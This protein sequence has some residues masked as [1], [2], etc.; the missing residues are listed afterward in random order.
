M[1]EKY[2]AVK[3][4]VPKMNRVAVFNDDFRDALKGHWSNPASLG[5]A[6]GQT[7]NE[8][9]VKYAIVGATFH[10]QIVY[11]YVASTKWAWSISPE[12]SI[13]YLS[14]HDNYTFYDKLKLSRPDANL[15]E[16]ARMVCLAGAVLFFSQGVPFLHAG[17]E[18]LRTKRGNGNSYNAPDEI[19]QIDWS[20]KAIFSYVSDF[21]RKLISLRKKHPAFRMTSA[22]MIQ[23]NLRFSKHYMPGVVAFELTG[24]ANGDEWENILVVFN[25]NPDPIV[26]P[27]KHRKWKEI[28]NGL[29]IDENGLAERETHAVFVPPI[30][31]LML[32]SE[33][34]PIS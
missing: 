29:A 27:V 15:P 14:C 23:K 20:R 1:D 18:M 3:G 11:N 7:L 24:H 12:Q 22:A 26:F 8:E 34:N 4:N 6:S 13:N 2:R 19:N 10:P 25:N 31:T 33:K 30:A 17:I 16:L 9:S 5:F 32:V 28:V 21:F